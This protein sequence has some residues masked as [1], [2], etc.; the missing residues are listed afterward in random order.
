ME[1]LII[2]WFIS[3]SMTIVL[4]DDEENGF[5]DRFMSLILCLFVGFGVF[6]F[7]LGVVLKEIL[8]K[9]RNH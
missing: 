4:L 7:V 9:D 6:P 3:T 8:E 5:W 1:T 2:Y